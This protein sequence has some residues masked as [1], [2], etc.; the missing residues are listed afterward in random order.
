MSGTVF[1]PL[2]EE[3]SAC[4]EALVAHIGH[5]RWVQAAGADSL[6]KFAVTTDGLLFY[7]QTSIIRP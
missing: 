6:H 3:R 4:V 5:P 1:S 7:I 2:E